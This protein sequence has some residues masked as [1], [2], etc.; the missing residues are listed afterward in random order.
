[1]SDGAAIVLALS[2]AGGALVAVPVPLPVALVVVALAFVRR[3]PV[4]LCLGAALLASGCAAR[5]W[6]GLRPASSHAWSGVATLVS[7]PG[8][9]DGA[10]RVDLRLGHRRVEAWAR[11][12][13]AGR[14]RDRLAGERV[15]VAGRLEPVPPAARDRLARRHVGARLSIDDVGPWAFGSPVSRLANGVRRTLLA[16]AASL[17]DDRRALFAGFVL[18]DDRDQ[19]VEDVDDFRASGLTHLLVV[20]GQNVAFV[21]ALASPLLGRMSLGGRLAAGVVLVVLFGFVTRW[22]PS[23]L[24]AEA[25]AGVALVASTLGRPVSSLRLLALAVTGV[26]LVDPLLVGSVSFLLSAGACAGI[27]L[28]AHPLAAALPGPRPLVSAFAVTLA[29]QLGVAP[30]LVPVFGGV[31]VAA[32]P[33]NLLAV[34]AAGPV[35]M[36]GLAAGL[37]AGVVGGAVARAVHVPTGLLVAWVAAV[38]RISARLPL[39]ELRMPHVALITASACLLAVARHR[40]RA[41]A[42]V[43]MVATLAAPAFLDRAPRQAWAAPVVR[44]ARLWQAGAASVVE[45]DRASPAALLPALRRWRVRRIDVLV[46]ARR[47]AAGVAATLTRR[48]PARLVL[49]DAGTEVDAGGLRVRVER[50]ATRLV[51]VVRLRSSE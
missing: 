49:A 37:P 46:L 45:L 50:Q 29:A 5:A 16:G 30:V 32:L 28:F 9:F 36:W 8:D 19:S 1:M 7:D 11:G 4:V 35:M 6:A 42:A 44:G 38:A 10:V 34:P 51:A 18:G 14:L 31:P 22:E 43:A 20:S 3:S 27:A 24:R 26:L 47:S 13:A 12:G 33:A 41:V 21:L 25:M 40:V 15:S 39:G 17:P 2:T 23:V 48:V